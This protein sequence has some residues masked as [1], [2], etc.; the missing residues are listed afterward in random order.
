MGEAQIMKL[1]PK[2]EHDA[3]PVVIFSGRPEMVSAIW[4]KSQKLRQSKTLGCSAKNFYRGTQRGLTQ[5]R[6]KNG[7]PDVASFV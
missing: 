4:Q 1:R 7:D 6:F 2:F 5:K 3:D